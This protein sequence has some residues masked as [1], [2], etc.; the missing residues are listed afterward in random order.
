MT[1]VHGFDSRTAHQKMKQLPKKFLRSQ[2]RRKLWKQAQI[3]IKKL[4][5]VIPV[6]AVYVRG[7]FTSK[8]KRPADVDFIILLQTKSKKN[9]R[10]SF[11]VVIAPDNKHGKEILKDAE[12]WMKQKYGAKNSETVRLK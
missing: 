8:K 5:R 11:D 10:W 12:L 6:S 9:E 4:N 2:Y 7:S 3:I 1:N